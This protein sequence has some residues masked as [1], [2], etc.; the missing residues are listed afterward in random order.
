MPNTCFHHTTFDGKEINWYDGHD[1]GL[2]DTL[3]DEGCIKS[4]IYFDTPGELA[5]CINEIHQRG[6]E[7]VAFHHRVI[8]G[9]F[10]LPLNDWQS[11]SET[12]VPYEWRYCARVEIKWKHFAKYNN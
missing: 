2:E 9:K 1:L 5:D 12:Y 3:D 11:E 7:L 8:E 6:Y 4:E 10:K